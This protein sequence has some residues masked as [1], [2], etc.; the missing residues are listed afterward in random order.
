MTNALDPLALLATGVHT[1]PGVYALLLGSGVSTGAGVP[2]GWGVVRELVRRIATATHHGDRAA[3]DAAVED[4][5]QWWAAQGDGAPL[6]YSNLLTALGATPAARRALLAG[7]FEPTDDDV[8]GGLRVPSA[9]HRAIAQLVKRGYIR[10]ILTTNFD[11]LTEKALEDAGVPP[12]VLTRPEAVVGLTPL[13]HAPVTVIKLHGDYADLDMRN[14]LEELSAYPPEWDALLDRVFD[15]YGLVICGWS[16]DWDKA[17]VAA[18]ERTRARRYPLYWDSRSSRGSAATRLLA[19]HRGAVITA[20]SADAL[21]SGLLERVDALER[22]GEPPLATAMAV[23]RLKR[24]L[25]D[26]A[27]RI[28][29]HDLVLGA[30]ASPAAAVRDGTSAL[31]QG[32]EVGQLLQD[33]FAEYLR[34]TE[35]LLALV[36]AGVYHDRDRVHSDLWV[37]SVQRLLQARTIPT[38]T[39]NDHVDASRHY[40]ALLVMRAAGTVAAHLGRDDILLRLLTEPT[41]RNPFGRRERR[42]AFQVLPEYVVA[43][44]G[45]VNSMPRWNGTWWRYPPS[46]LLREDLREPLRPYLTDDQDYRASCDRY[47]YLVAV[48]AHSVPAP[49]GGAEPGEFIGELVWTAEGR[50]PEIDFREQARQDPDEWPWW[51]VIGGRDN[52]ES[53]LDELTEALNGM[54]SHR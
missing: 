47:E 7:F 27:R 2:T 29:L 49:Y 19:Q 22:L 45:V 28:D 14:T 51:P 43:D 46:H 38:G 37:T 1:Q 17:L 11:R 50:Q 23:T 36:T 32:S 4:P 30:T 34:V 53:F 44:P 52:H 18:L 40:P 39:V 26:P 13:P 15:E 5:E 6:G 48:L 9:A 41:Y 16:A 20:A 25:P 54:T 10:V 8:A 3:V 12:Q 35:P 31:M 21:F 33:L 24:Y 42:P